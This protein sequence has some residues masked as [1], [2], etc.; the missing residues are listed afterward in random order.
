MSFTLLNVTAV[1]SC[2]CFLGSDLGFGVMSFTVLDLDVTAR[3][4][5]LRFL[6]CNL[7]L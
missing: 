6:G 3:F 1:L 7:S 5:G 2:L 4:R